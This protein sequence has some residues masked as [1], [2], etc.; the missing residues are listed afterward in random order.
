MNV[1]NFFKFL[2][3]KKGRE[4]PFI[5]KLIH[6]PEMLKPEE[7]NVDGDLYLYGTPITSLP[8]GLSVGGNLYLGGTQ[9]TSLPNDLKVYGDLSLA[10]AQI[11]SLP[12]GL[13]VGGDLSLRFTPIAE[14]Y[15]KDNIKKMCPGIKGDIYL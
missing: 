2:K 6:N 9:I 12:E 10:Y 8:E 15:T 1:Y 5:F 7:F 3:E 4:F 11:T 13:S 14:K